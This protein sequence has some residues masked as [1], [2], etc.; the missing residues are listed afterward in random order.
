M[1][2][3]VLKDMAFAHLTPDLRLTEASANLARYAAEPRL[4]A[5]PSPPAAEVFWELVGAED[6]LQAMLRGDQGAIVWRNLNRDQDGGHTLIFTLMVV[7]RDHDRPG[8]GLMLIIEDTTH[9]SHLEQQ[10]LNDRNQL[11]LLQDQLEIANLELQRINWF[12]TTLASMV[13]HDL[14]APLSAIR[15]LTSQLATRL[16]DEGGAAWRPMLNDLHAEIERLNTMI[17]SVLD[18]GQIDHG[19]LHLALAPCNL[20]QLA[21]TIVHRVRPLVERRQLHLNMRWAAEPLLVFA[22][23]DRV[24]QVLYNLLDNAIKYTPR[25]GYITVTTELDGAGH[26]VFDIFN[27][28]RGLPPDKLTQLFNLYERAQ[29][30][31]APD[32]NGLGLGLYFVKMLTEAHGGYVTVINQPDVGVS[33]RTFWP[34]HL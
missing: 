29:A 3:T 24:G 11:R 4:L 9:A 2:R 20:T 16:P 12:K 5:V 23:P 33:F 19:H 32:V 30:D 22:D 21:E 25:G 31:A 34:L 27:S 7:P 13:A 18:I 6:D 26:G 1:A 17:G 28:G 8:D 14:R 10:V 15:M